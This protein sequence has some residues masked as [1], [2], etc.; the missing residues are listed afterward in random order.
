MRSP[1]LVGVDDR[2]EGLLPL[3]RVPTPHPPPPLQPTTDV[4]LPLVP[5]GPPTLPSSPSLRLH[6]LP[7]LVPKSMG[8]ERGDGKG[9]C[10]VGRASPASC[11]SASCPV[12]CVS[13]AT[14]ALS[15]DHHQPAATSS[16]MIS[17]HLPRPCII[18]SP[19]RPARCRCTHTTT[20][21][22]A[23][24]CALSQYPYCGHNRPARR[25]DCASCVLFSPARSYALLREPRPT[26]VALIVRRRTHT[27][28]MVRPARCSSATLVHPLLRTPRPQYS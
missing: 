5:P 27:A 24:A 18:R 13:S 25:D 21:G 1:R 15:A 2:I 6:L 26:S 14:A 9:S 7:P 10:Y 22:H 23:V 4:G 28:T 11:T 17:E 20:S 8:A 12:G 3:S 19:L 16:C